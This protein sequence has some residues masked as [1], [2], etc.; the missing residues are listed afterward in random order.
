MKH[1]L[2]LI[3]CLAV[4]NH[5]LKAQTKNYPAGIAEPYLWI[6]STDSTDANRYAITDHIH[7]TTYK[8]TK[9]LQIEYLNQHPLFQYTPD[10]DFSTYIKASQAEQLSLFIVYGTTQRDKEQML[11]SLSQGAMPKLAATT[12]RLADLETKK[13]RAYP[14]SLMPAEYKIHYYQHRKTYGKNKNPLVWS[15]GQV[16]EGLPPQSFNGT[17]A[18]VLVYDRVL[19]PMEMQQVAS[20]LGIKY[21]ISLSQLE[22]KNYYNSQGDK[23]WDYQS[24]Q[25]Y[26][27]NITAVGSDL[28]GQINQPKSQNANDEQVVSMFLEPINA[29]SVPDNYFVFWSDNGKPLKIKKQQEGQPKGLERKWV[30]DK[31]QRENLKLSWHFNPQKI[32]KDNN[33]SSED[34][35]R[36]Y[37]LV[38]DTAKGFKYQPQSTQY[39]RLQSIEDENPIEFKDWYQFKNAQIGYTIWEA[40][41]MF[42]HLDITESQCSKPQSGRVQWHMVGGTAPYDL[43][44]ISL[45]DAKKTYHWTENK[46]RGSRQMAL[47]SGK[48]R[49]QIKDKNNQIYTQEF[50]LSDQDMPQPEFNEEYILKGSLVMDLDQYLPKGTYNVEWY[51]DGQLVSTDKKLLVNQTGDYQVRIRNAKGCQSLS[52][53]SVLGTAQTQEAKMVLYPNPSLDGHYQLLASFPKTTSGTLSIYNMAGQQLHQETFYNLSQYQ[54]EGYIHQSGVYVIQIKT[55][56]GTTTHKLIVK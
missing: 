2:L 54:Y 16:L 6:K 9:A 25:S 34:S 42:A 37:W 32:L 39:F 5:R 4:G 19:S 23:I 22:Y 50:Y 10:L 38:V 17:I 30:L 14:K 1:I 49:Y 46:A 55:T 45:D 13:Y 47:S 36:Y 44:L 26:N 28:L 8:A 27:Q 21:G 12:L 24:H 48:Y 40:P 43:E 31:P 41:E 33:T 56:F 52:K 29:N 7:K 35:K 20:Y 53:F 15:L 3:F 11:W 51:H 18:E